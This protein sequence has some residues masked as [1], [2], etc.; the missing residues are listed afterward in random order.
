MGSE[1][2]KYPNIECSKYRC[3]KP[4]APLYILEE[5]ILQREWLGVKIKHYCNNHKKA[6]ACQY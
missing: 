3:Q 6:I 2:I 5:R 1:M 4:K